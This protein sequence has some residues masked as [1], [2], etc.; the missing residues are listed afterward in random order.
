MVEDCPDAKPPGEATE[1]EPAEDPAEEAKG[2]APEASAVE[3]DSAHGYDAP[4]RQ[5]FMQIAITGQGE[6][7]FKFAVTQVRVLDGA[8]TKLG[9]VKTRMPTIWKSEGY[10]AWDEMV[11]PMN[12]VKASYK[13]SLPTWDD[14]SKQVGPNYGSAYMLEADV[15]INGVSKTIRSSPVVP[16]PPDMVET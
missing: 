15:S 5:S 12:A 6:S 10:A 13:V 16:E 7:S 11:M 3:G 2:R 8:G 4:C 1:V 14:A 9:T